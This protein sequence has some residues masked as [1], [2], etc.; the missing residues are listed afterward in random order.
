M[1]KE[2]WKC[3]RKKEHTEFQEEQYLF[4]EKY[5]S[6]NHLDAIKMPLMDFMKIRFFIC[7]ILQRKIINTI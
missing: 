4:N 6:K 3:I 1:K 2:N 5:D 7:F